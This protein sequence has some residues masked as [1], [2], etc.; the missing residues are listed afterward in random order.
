MIPAMVPTMMLQLRERIGGQVGFLQP[1]ELGGF[2]FREVREPAGLRVDHNFKAIAHEP[3]VAE[4]RPGIGLE[5]V[6]V[7]DQTLA[8][9]GRELQSVAPAEAGEDAAEFVCGV[10]R[11]LEFL[12]I[13]WLPEGKPL[14]ET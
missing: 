6:E 9:S 2:H 3:G 8:Q 10:V 14:V 1:R 5:M 11:K 13:S 7:V 4:V 12:G